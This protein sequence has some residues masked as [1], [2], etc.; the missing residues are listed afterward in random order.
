MSLRLDLRDEASREFDEAFDHYEAQ[1]PGLG[2]DFIV[3]VQRVFDQIVAFPESH[4]VVFADVRRA[5]VTRFPY[6]VFYRAH[7]DRI[8][9]LAVFHGRRDPSTWKRRM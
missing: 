6:S 5:V 9:V 2:I 1:S 8:E 7:A 4:A 3:R